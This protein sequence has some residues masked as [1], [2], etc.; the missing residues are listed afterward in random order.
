MDKLSY[1][2]TIYLF[3]FRLGRQILW[4]PMRNLFIPIFLNCW[5]AKR[6]LENMFVSIEWMRCSCYFFFHFFFLLLF[7]ILFRAHAKNKKTKII[8]FHFQNDLHRA[9]QKSQSAL[10]QQLTILSATLLCL[11]FTRYKAR[12]KCNIHTQT[13]LWFVWVKSSSSGPANRNIIFV[14]INFI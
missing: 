9:M 14:F 11:V 7:I 6:S 13:N 3:I 5:L 8:T 2:S 10:S 1:T 4:P 12:R